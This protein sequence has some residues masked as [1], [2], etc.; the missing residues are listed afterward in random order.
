VER[1]RAAPFF[2]FLGCLLL[3]VN[4]ADLVRL[5]LS[6]K[7]RLLKLASRCGR[8][9]RLICRSQRLSAPNVGKLSGTL[10][11]PVSVPHLRPS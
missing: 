2:R 3:F 7:A 5:A 6:R 1:R 8:P 4:L 10:R 9:P 11:W